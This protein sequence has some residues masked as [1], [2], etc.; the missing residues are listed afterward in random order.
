M[1][2]FA[3]TKFC[4]RSALVCMGIAGFVGLGLLQ[5][6]PASA[7]PCVRIY[8]IYYNSPGSDTG[9]NASLNAEWISLYNSCPTRRYLKAWKIRD[10]ARHTYTFGSVT[11]GGHATVRVHTGKG[12]NTGTNLYWNQGWY[13]W[14]NNG[15]TA[16]LRDRSGALLDT[17]SYRDPSESFNW[18]NC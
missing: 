8:R 3:F 10:A 9:S 4:R 7:A 6:A 5:A 16:Y 14:N 2:D 12:T 17:C 15:D 11:L 18:T 13:I 1:A